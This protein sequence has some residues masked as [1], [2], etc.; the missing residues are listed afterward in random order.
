MLRFPSLFP[1]FVEFYVFGEWAYLLYALKR[2]YNTSIKE[3]I[4][5]K[6]DEVVKKAYENDELIKLLSGDPK[7]ILDENGKPY[8]VEDLKSSY[9]PSIEEEDPM[10]LPAILNAIEDMYRSFNRAKGISDAERREQKA[11][12]I[13]ALQ[14]SIVKMSSS[15]EVTHVYFAAEIYFILGDRDQNMLYFPLHVI[16]DDIK[17]AV[18]MGVDKYKENLKKTKLYAGKNNGLGLW[19]VLICWNN[20]VP[21]TIKL[22]IT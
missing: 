11:R 18:Q 2:E 16:N 20:Y 22:N 6:F 10:C 14:D 15:E 12:L 7:Y 5:D 3:L 13:K 9:A 17:K 21:D 4:M 1:K 8:L 19:G